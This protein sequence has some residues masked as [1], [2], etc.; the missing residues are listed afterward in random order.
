V[1]LVEAA[2]E[3]TDRANLAKPPSTRFK[4][5]PPTHALD[6]APPA[7]LAAPPLLV[8]IN[9]QRGAVHHLSLS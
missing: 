7:P 6:A 1:E 3:G 5:L 4:P 8:R 9:W 2:A